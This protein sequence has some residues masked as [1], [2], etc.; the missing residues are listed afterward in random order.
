MAHT[1]KKMSPKKKAP[2]KKAHA[3]REQ[4]AGVGHR[5][6]LDRCFWI[7]VNL[8]ADVR[9]DEAERLVG[10]SYE[11]VCAGLT[12]RQKAALAALSA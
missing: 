1:P 7:S 4:Y 2:A 6:H 9:A 3:L 12:R 10:H 8:D 5:W 11:L